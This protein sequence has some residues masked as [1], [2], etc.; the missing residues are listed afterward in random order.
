M[1]NKSS[2]HLILAF[3]A[4]LLFSIFIFVESYE[5]YFENEFKEGYGLIVDTII[6]DLI[7]III[8]I[9]FIIQKDFKN[10]MILWIYL[11]GITILSFLG[12]KIP[13]ALLPIITTAICLHLIQMISKSNKINT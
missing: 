8:S 2:I 4:F 11:T 10:L 9:I 13:L 6:F 1:L 3:L 12:F 5:F 7:M